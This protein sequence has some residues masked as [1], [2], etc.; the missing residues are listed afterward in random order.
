MPPAPASSLDLTPNRSGEYLSGLEADIRSLHE[1]AE[2]LQDEVTVTPLMPVIARIMNLDTDLRDMTDSAII[3]V[4]QEVDECKRQL[5]ALSYDYI[6]QIISKPDPSK[7]FR[8]LANA[9]KFEKALRSSSGRKIKMTDGTETLITPALINALTRFRFSLGTPPITPKGIETIEK[10]MFG[11]SLHDIYAFRDLL[12]CDRGVFDRFMG[13][14]NRLVEQSTHYT[15]AREKKNFEK[16]A[17]S[18]PAM[19][20]MRGFSK[21]VITGSSDSAV[22]LIREHLLSKHTNGSMPLKGVEEKYELDDNLINAMTADKSSIFIVRAKSVDHN[23]FRSEILHEKWNGLIGRLVIIDESENAQ[24]SGTALVYSMHPRITDALAKFHVKDSGTPANTQMNLRLILENFRDRDLQDLAATVD[25]KIAKLRAENIHVRGA[26]EVRKKEWLLTAQQDYAALIKFREFLTFVTTL[27]EG[28]EKSLTALNEELINSSTDLSIDYFFKNLK[29]KGYKAIAVPQGGGRRELV[30]I[31]KFHLKKVGTKLAQF[32]TVKL[33]NLRSRLAKLKSKN[34]IAETST[35]SESAAVTRAMDQRRSPNASIRGQAAQPSAVVARVKAAAGEALYKTEN[36][37]EQMVAK[38]DEILGVNL[39]GILKQAVTRILKN[40]GVES[41][42]KMLERGPFRAAANKLRAFQ[43]NFR[44]G[45]NGVA[46]G[47][48]WVLDKIRHGLETDDLDL[49]GRMLNDIENGSFQPSLALPELSWTVPDVMPEED[50]PGKNYIRIK[51]RPDGQIDFGSLESHL[52]EKARALSAFP[53]LFELYCS[54]ILIYF[55]DPH[56][57]TSQVATPE[58][59][60]KLLDIASKYGLSIASDEPYHKQVAKE[61]KDKNG[62]VCLAEFYEQNRS[63]FPKSVT[64]S[65][66]LSTTKW[67]MGAGRRTGILVSN[68]QHT[69]ESCRGFEDFVTRNIDGANTM[70]LYMDRETLKTGLLVKKVCKALEPAVILKNPIKAVDKVLKENFAT[71]DSKVFNLPVYNILVEARNDL[72]RL[73]V[74][75]AT[76]LD[77]KQYLSEVISKLKDLRL[78]KQTQRDSA[79]RSKAAVQAIKNLSSEF[80]G[81][82]ERCIKPQGPFYFCVQLDNTAQDSGLQPFLEAIAAARKIDVVPIEK[83]YARFAFGGLLEGTKAGYDLLTLAIETDLKILMQYWEKFK[84]ARAELNK[85]KDLDPINNAIKKLF[86][87]GEIELATTIGEKSAYVRAAQKLGSGKKG[88]LTNRFSAT[89]SQYLSSIEPNS[90]ANIITIRAVDC[91]DINQFINSQTFKELYEYLLLQVKEKIPELD[92]LTSDEVI[93]NFGAHQLKE[94]FKTRDFKGVRKKLFEEIIVKVANLWFDPA[95]IKILALEFEKGLDRSIR[96]QAL[97]GAENKISQFLKDIIQAFVGK[98]RETEIKYRPT[99]QAG[100]DVITDVK[101]GRNLPQ[102]MQTTIGKTEFAGETIPTDRSPSMVT[103]G[104]ARVAGFDRGIY[105]RD[106]D[107][108]D[109]PTAD[110][111]RKRFGEFADVLNPKD[112]VCKMVQVGPSRLM[113]VMHRSFSH[114]LVEELRLMPQ[115]DASLD[116]LENL[117]PDAI[118]FLGIP[119][120]TIGENYRIGYYIED[121]IPVSWVEANDITDYMG[122]LKKPLLTVTNERVKALGGLPIHGQGAII[123]AK[124]GMRKTGVKVGDSGTGKSEEFIAMV[125]QIIAGFGGAQNIESVELLAGDML[126]LWRGDD[127]QIYMIGTE[128]GDFMRL[129]DISDNWQERFR[130]LL[131]KASKTNVDHPTNPRAT[132]PGLCDSE[133]ILRPTRV[134]MVSGINNFEKAPNGIAFQE[135]PDTENFLCSLYPRGYRREKGTSGDQPNIYASIFYSEQ[136]DSDQ[137]LTKYKEELDKLLG[138]DLLLAPNGK[139]E[140]AILAFNDIPGAVFRAR[141]MVRDLFVGKAININKKI[142]PSFSGTQKCKII[143]IDYNPRENRF[144]ATLDTNGGKQTVPLNREIFD[145][146][147]NPI[148]STYCGNPFIDPRGMDVILREFARAFKEAGVITSTIYTELAVPGEQFSG[149]ARA[150]QAEIEF[151]QTDPRINE[152]FQNNKKVAT[153]LPEKYGTKVFGQG[154]IPQK[155]EAYNLYLNEIQ[156]SHNIHLVDGKGQTIPIK[157]PYFTNI[158]K[159]SDTE[160]EPKLMTPEIAETLRDILCNADAANVNVDDYEPNLAAYAHIKAADTMDEL[161]YQ[162]LLAEGIMGLYYEENILKRYVREVKFAEKTAKM[163]RDN[164]M[165]KISGTASPQARA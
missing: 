47:T 127:K 53:E 162:I 36:F 73:A 123:T 102:W 56:N 129:T 120:K 58:A 83:G 133:K 164:G 52:E 142:L 154:A 100:Y 146:V 26:E 93:A 88:R 110:F 63:R 23:S 59:K 19:V 60:L 132:I 98:N 38:L 112:Y 79:K 90:P 141:N 62:D 103:P 82:E 114:Y 37:I 165:I 32:K 161:I 89:A 152:R 121:N 163:M 29:D 44:R 101:G 75:G 140:N 130:D 157:T 151:I 14:V 113:L 70:S 51:T 143:D 111:F 104:A 9:N 34:G 4:E 39:P 86:P 125:E 22:R 61:I 65:T 144:Y 27:K 147:F 118:S 149:P 78:D 105:R 138:W 117:Q 16:K 67:A 5:A 158:K 76:P 91:K 148:A 24:R 119:T 155:L 1:F 153:A 35:G 7:V 137:L 128:Q 108:K 77:Y 85:Q 96:G 17:T 30:H 8:V 159:S 71:P 54:N 139:V 18:F 41:A 49:A 124:N 25:G 87:G 81:L 136:P 131:E 122:Y 46:D 97:H 6:N 3:L 134:N 15:T 94:K 80:P 145:Q 28:D 42:A 156:Q 57:P 135:E 55:N 45:V 40:Q 92:H 43:G 10:I 11:G 50:F 150:A 84:T 106:G 72:D 31:G 115:F 12:G 66:A 48:L 33:D 126:S 2:P 64:I 69:S 160:F 20:G 21:T 95:T 74:R 116:D 109:A 107:G 13:Q 68:D 99:F